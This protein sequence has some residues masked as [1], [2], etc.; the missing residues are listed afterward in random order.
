MG[1]SDILYLLCIITAQFKILFL[2]WSNSRTAMQ[3]QRIEIYTATTAML[4]GTEFRQIDSH[5][6]CRVM[7]C[8]SNTITRQ[9]TESE[10]CSRV[11]LGARV[12]LLAFKSDILQYTLYHYYCFYYLFYACLK[13]TLLLWH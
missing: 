13:V 4:V 3:Q 2:S 7:G 6:F 10:G 8:L 11:S 5:P 12:C 1:Q 9:N